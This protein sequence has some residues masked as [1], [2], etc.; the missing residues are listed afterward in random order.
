MPE[1]IFTTPTG[2][3]EDERP[4]LNLDKFPD[5]MISG[6]IFEE[7]VEVR[8][9]STTPNVSTPEHLLQLW[10]VSMCHTQAYFEYQI[11]KAS[12]WCW[13]IWDTFSEKYK[14]PECM[15]RLFDEWRQHHYNA[16]N[17]SDQ[18]R[19][20]LLKTVAFYSIGELNYWLSKFIL[21]VRKRDSA[22]YPQN[23]L[24]SLIADIQGVFHQRKILHQLFK[25]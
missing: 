11:L 18:Y 1:H 14:T 24:V 17:V 16:T 21:E 15:S 7:I 2:I 3:M 25:D 13:N 20:V 22:R 4:I 19:T 6:L 9:D 23:S 12:E 5:D 10:T 8:N